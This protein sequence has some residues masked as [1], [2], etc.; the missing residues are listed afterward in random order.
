MYHSRSC[1]CN[2]S[3]E[4]LCAV[5]ADWAFCVVSAWLDWSCRWQRLHKQAPS[6]TL[7]WE[8]EGGVNQ[9][10]GNV[11]V[12]GRSRPGVCLC[13]RW[14]QEKLFV[15]NAVC[16]LL[17]YYNSLNILNSY[18]YFFNFLKGFTSTCSQWHEHA[19]LSLV[20]FTKQ[21][22]VTYQYWPSVFAQSSAKRSDRQSVRAFVRHVLEHSSLRP[23]RFGVEGHAA[24]CA[25][26]LCFRLSLH[27]RPL[28]L[29][30]PVFHSDQ[31]LHRGHGCRSTSAVLV[32]TP[33]FERYW[34]KSSTLSHN[35]IHIRRCKRG[36]Q[37]HLRSSRVIC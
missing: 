36:L 2:C 22:R 17:L 16:I 6:I 37:S 26:P 34:S 23:P 27:R 13:Q 20:I 18:I 11:T 31:L 15:M 35:V 10:Q 21:L 12:F 4:R 19:C 5:C 9:E 7:S 25:V 29:L 24:V 3:C 1:L 30:K 33:R 14:P 28:F 32:V 8:R